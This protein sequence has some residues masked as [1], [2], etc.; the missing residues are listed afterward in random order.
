MGHTYPAADGQAGCRDLQ[1]SIAVR[2][3]GLGNRGSRKS[4]QYGNKPARTCV[5]I[6]PTSVDSTRLLN[7]EFR[8][9]S[10]M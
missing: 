1:M 6:F 3:G 9:E 4:R 8:T 7:P 10:N 2:I 5:K